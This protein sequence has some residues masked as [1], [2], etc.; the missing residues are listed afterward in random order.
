MKILRHRATMSAVD[1]DEAN[2]KD[3]PRN[4]VP[5]SIIK[6]IVRANDRGR[7]SEKT[8][9]QLNVTSSVVRKLDG[10]IAIPEYNDD[11]IV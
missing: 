6:E 1:N 2:R 4:H 8:S 10:Q 7:D 11:G 3:K 5:I 9:R